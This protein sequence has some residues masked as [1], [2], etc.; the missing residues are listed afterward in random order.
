[1]NRIQKSILVVAT[2]ASIGTTPEAFPYVF[3]RAVLSATLDEWIKIEGR[4]P[5]IQSARGIIRESYEMSHAELGSLSTDT[6]AIEMHHMVDPHDF[7]TALRYLVG[8]YV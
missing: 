1:M 6:Q 8:Q 2:L 3:H 7:R 4:T 5:L